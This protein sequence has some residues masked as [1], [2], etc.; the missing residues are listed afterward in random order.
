MYI[1]TATLHALLLMGFGAG[2]VGGV[3]AAING[4]FGGFRALPPKPMSVSKAAKR[5]RAVFFIFRI[6]V[7]AI[8][9][10]MITFWFASDVVENSLSIEK[11]F[12]IQ[13]AVGLSGSLLAP[14]NQGG[15]GAS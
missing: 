2:A 5:T 4:I 8:L 9:G 11:L 1:P 10:A 15:E 7:G 12:F 13:F 3:V 6:F 14:R